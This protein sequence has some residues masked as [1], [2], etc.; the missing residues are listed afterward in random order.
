LGAQCRVGCAAGE[1]GQ[2]ARPV[3][4]EFGKVRGERAEGAMCRVDD[5]VPVEAVGG[6]GEGLADGRGVGGQHVQAGVRLWCGGQCG[7]RCPLVIRW[8]GP[9]D[10]L[11]LAVPKFDAEKSRWIVAGG[12]DDGRVQVRVLPDESAEGRGGGCSG[13]QDAGQA[14]G[15][16]QIGR[17]VGE[18]S[19]AS[20][21]VVADQHAAAESAAGAAW[22]TAANR[23]ASPKPTPGRPRQPSVVVEDDRIS[24][25]RG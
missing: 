4:G 20:P 10:A 1:E 22:S 11:A 18:F 21:A 25:P 13:P 6:G 16:E 23:W 12:D 9:R 7:D 24:S 14:V 2:R 5:E 17:E 3:P 8:R 19:G 15:G